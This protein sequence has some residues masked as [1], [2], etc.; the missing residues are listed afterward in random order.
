MLRSI[1]ADLDPF[2]INDSKKLSN[3]AKCKWYDEG[4]K[5][6]RYFV[7]LI[8]KREAA[9]QFKEFKDDKGGVFTN[10]KDKL[11]HAKSF[12]SK[13]YSS[14]TNLHNPNSLLNK[15]NTPK[16]DSGQN[17]IID[18]PISCDELFETLKTCKES[19]PGNDS[20]T[21]KCYIYFWE[22]I[23]KYLLDAWEYSLQV[24]TLCRDHR[25]STITLLE[26]KG[27]DPAYL[28]NLRPIT[29]SNCDI[30]IITKTLA[31]RVGRVLPTIIHK[32][33]TAHNKG[34][35]VHVNLIFLD[36]CKNKSKELNI[37][38]A[39]VSLDVRKAFD[40]VDH[41]YMYAC[42][43]KYG[44]SDKF[45]NTVKLLYTDIKASVMIN[46]FRSEEFDIEQSV[47]QGDA[48]SCDLF[49]ICVDPLIR[50]LNNVPELV[51]PISGVNGEK[52]SNSAGY[53]DD[54]SVVTNASEISIQIIYN[55]YYEFSNSS[56]L[57]L[58]AEKTEIISNS[59]HTVTLNANNNIITLKTL[60][61]I[62]ICGKTFSYKNER[63]TQANIIDKIDKLKLKLN[64]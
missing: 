50:S 53:A 62:K 64:I 54:V 42:L 24:G 49:V 48:L 20:I 61:E 17:D 13:L 6:N 55:K 56:G 44:F 3:R 60:P 18:Y 15:I 51:N 7:N 9:Q 27:K 38:L 14:Q 37:P 46:G 29:L 43:A 10:I 25:S 57:F 19:A 12:Y 23:G 32:S 1:Q 2:L 33:Q 11:E 5:S 4:E 31:N 35:Q 22:I 39:I 59:L 28:N 8:K 40:S 41:K 21:Y 26:K 16:L 47:K 36:Y 34:P 63:E 52:L 58:N 30:K 45:I